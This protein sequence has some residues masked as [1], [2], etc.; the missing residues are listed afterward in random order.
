MPII[1]TVL[2]NHGYNTALYFESIQPPRWEVLLKSD[3]IGFSVSSS[4]FLETYE[5]VQKI[6]KETNCPII[7][8]GPH[9]TFLPDEA[10]QFGDF[11]VR[12][13]GEKTIIELLKTL[14]DEKNE[15]K[16]IK[17]L[18]W[19]D[20]DGTIHHNEN[21]PF[22]IN[23]HLVPDYSLIVGFKKYMKNFIWKISQ[24][25]IPVNT[26]RGCVQ[27]CIFC[28]IPE[29]CGRKIRYKTIGS[30][31]SDI[32]EQ[33]EFSGRRFVYFTDDNF[34][35]HPKRTKELLRSIIKENLN[36]H[37]S[38]QVRCDIAKDQELMDLIAA[39]GCSFV[40]I[41]F[42]SINDNT[43]KMYKKG[44]QTLSKITHSIKE[45]HKRRIDIH[46][47][48]VIGADSD[49]PKTAIRTARWAAEQGIC[50]LQMLPLVPL[51]G[52]EIYTQLK[53]QNRL[54]K[55]S[56]SI[57]KEYIP[58]GSG[59]F[60]IFK[61]KRITAIDL[62]MEILKAYR[63]FYNS[64]QI[65]KRALRIFRQGLRPTVFNIIGCQIIKKCK[66]EIL[67]HVAWLKKITAGRVNGSLQNKFLSI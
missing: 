57:L 51:P 52:T 66:K 8:G 33:I 49:G 26:A 6:K 60:V 39:A 4:C 59:N 13:E 28:V 24:S 20:P 53:N 64:K 54:Y 25:A 22:D 67:E 38:I 55:A 29:M 44:N 2:K 14:K 30:V 10:L 36:I 65:I 7:F 61:P 50:S 63:I 16:Y 45:F 42:E 17:G 11:V 19:R 56:N 58:Y 15:F 40:K 62:Q 35:A 12:G 3:I 43:L 23:F 9:V 37:F 27:K 18:S 48:F 21:R 34:A 31:I 32:Y 41:G 46:G 47:M 5:L 1:G